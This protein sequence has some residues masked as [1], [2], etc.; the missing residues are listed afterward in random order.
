M[1]FVFTGV[2][3]RHPPLYLG[4]ATTWRSSTRNAAARRVAMPTTNIGLDSVFVRDVPARVE[5]GSPPVANLDDM[6]A[7]MRLAA[8]AYAISPLPPVERVPNAQP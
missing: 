5:Q 4:P 8:E 6:A 7:A 2:S 3:H 1:R